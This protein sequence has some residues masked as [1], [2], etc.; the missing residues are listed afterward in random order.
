MG[1]QSAPATPPKELP[2]LTRAVSLLSLTKQ[3]SFSAQNGVCQPAQPEFLRIPCGVPNWASCDACMPPESEWKDPGFFHIATAVLGRFSFRRAFREGA[4]RRDGDRLAHGCCRENGTGAP[5]RE[6]ACLPR[7][8]RQGR[9]SGN[10]PPGGAYS[11]SLHSPCLAPLLGG[12][13]RCCW[14]LWACCIGRTSSSRFSIFNRSSPVTWPCRAWRYQWPARSIAKSWS[15]PFRCWARSHQASAS[16]TWAAW[17]V[18]G[19]VRSCWASDRTSASADLARCDRPR[20]QSFWVR[21]CQR[22]R[23]RLA[24]AS[25]GSA[26]R[27]E[28]AC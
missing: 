9:R 1:P 25:W 5:E 18:G 20:R 27:V 3:R 21:Q 10:A 22:P 11:T 19:E 6:V 16:L 12:R 14:A 4:K 7:P 24:A 8:L 2:D 13:R 17:V 15:S 23:K 28:W 26:F